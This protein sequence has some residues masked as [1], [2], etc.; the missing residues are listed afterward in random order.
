MNN[1][2]KKILEELKDSTENPTVIYPTFDGSDE[3]KFENDK[4][5][6][7][8]S[9]KLL[10]NYIT[11][12]E[13]NWNELKKYAK[14]NLYFYI[15]YKGED[16]E[17]DISIKGILEK[18]EELEGKSEQM[19]A[20]E[21]FE[22]LGYNLDRAEEDSRLYCKDILDKNTLGYKDSEMIYFDDEYNGIY[23][24]NKEHL[25]INELKA[26]NKQ[27]EELGW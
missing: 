23:F 7:P 10:F 9:C 24:T 26:I 27:I 14:E 20:K 1:E 25:N 11:Q 3:E 18:M 5:L 17:E 22:E 6:T 8:E 2:I 16:L 4:L 21:M 15:G 13:T 19:T 12:L